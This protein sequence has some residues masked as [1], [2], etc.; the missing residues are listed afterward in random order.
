MLLVNH[1]ATINKIYLISTQLLSKHA[2]LYNPAIWYNCILYDS[3][4]AAF[5]EVP[6]C[7]SGS[8]L[9]TFFVNDLQLAIKR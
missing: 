3:H 2:K 9:D 6:I 4:D 1:I 5:N 8:F 7:F